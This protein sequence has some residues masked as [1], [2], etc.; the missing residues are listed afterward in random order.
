MEFRILGPF[1]VTDDRRVLP[2]GGPRQRALRAVLLLNANRAI[3]TSR[4]TE[5]LWDGEAPATATNAIQVYVAHLR[6]LMELDRTA[7]TPYQ[8]L[9]SQ[10]QGYALRV[11]P[12]QV[13]S[14]SEWHGR[15][16][17]GANVQHFKCP[18]P[19]RDLDYSKGGRSAAV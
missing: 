16:Q 10:A 11:Q 7:S 18:D 6:R 19:D 9:V 5:L 14:T 13:G 15:L 1:E 2:L 4:L 17:H 8:L 12:D 3:S